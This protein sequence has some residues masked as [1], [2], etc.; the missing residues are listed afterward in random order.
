MN[1]MSNGNAEASGN[2]QLQMS[3]ANQEILDA[4]KRNHQYNPREFNLN[5]KGA[6]FFVIKSVSSNLYDFLPYPIAPGSSKNQLSSLI[7]RSNQ[8]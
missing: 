6:R 1:N 3:A 7:E 2:G 8:I 5:P 4:L